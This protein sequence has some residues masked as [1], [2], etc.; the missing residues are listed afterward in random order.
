MEL[1]PGQPGLL[2]AILDSVADY[3][4]MVLDTDGTVRIWGAGAERLFQYH[5]DDILGR[6]SDVLFMQSDTQQDVPQQE[7]DASLESSPTFAMRVYRRQDG[8]TFWADGT[9]SLMRDGSGGP[10]GYVKILHDATERQREIAQL[11]RLARVDPLTGLNNRIALAE[12][13]K[14]AAEAA[15]RHERSLIVQMIDLDRFKPVNDRLGHA[16]GDLLLQ[17]VAQRIVG[18]VRGTDVVARLGGDE[19]VVLQPDASDPAIGGRV[20]EKIVASLA[21]PFDIDG[22]TVHVGSSIGISVC[23]RDTQDPE[24]LLRMADVALFK[25]KSEMRGGY[26]YFSRQLDENAHRRGR[27]QRLLQRAVQRG[28][29]TVHFQPQVNVFTGAVIGVEALLRCTDA[30]LAHLSVE[31]I[32]KL[33]VGAGLVREI[34]ART[35]RASFQQARK[36]RD[37]RLPPMVMSL[38]LCAAELRDP[39]LLS[40]LENELVRAGLAPA[41]VE[42]EITEHDVL[43]EC[44]G[45]H[46]ILHALRALGVSVA[47]DDF[48]TGYSALGYLAKLPVDRIKL[49]RSFV[50]HVPEDS[51]SCAVVGAIVTLAHTL[52]LGVVAEGI[53][54]TQQARFFASADCEAVQ[55]YLYSPPLPGRDMTR[56]LQA[57]GRVGAH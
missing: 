17:Q 57:R 5:E 7:R 38:N 32:L 27:E 47:I 3:A 29:L 44:R 46:S 8:A 14:E 33:A 16:V 53:E 51:R 4:V 35:M 12:R 13:L 48:G 42:L 9:L 30:S 50:T 22:N 24:Q 6:L 2:E 18:T 40:L 31:E 45:D 19:F 43:E 37:M 23:P 52:D 25:V 21:Q 10:M 20:A 56:W 49:D 36:W 34:G 39:L 26:H 15:M 41:D 55:G 1:E 11:T 28:R 54:S